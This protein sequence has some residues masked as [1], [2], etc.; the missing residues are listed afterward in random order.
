MASAPARRLSVTRS[1]TSQIALGNSSSAPLTFFG[2][3]TAGFNQLADGR[4]PYGAGGTLLGVGVR[5]LP[6]DSAAAN[7]RPANFSTQAQIK[8]FLHDLHL[9]RSDAKIS[10]LVGS[11]QVCDDLLGNMPDYHALAG[12]VAQYGTQ[13]AGDAVAA[14]IPGGFPAMPFTP[15]PVGSQDQITAVVSPAHGSTYSTTRTGGLLIQVTAFVSLNL[16]HGFS[17]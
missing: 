8:G 2:G 3:Q 16:T 10:F 12:M 11:T 1:F 5:L 14:V 15:H 6:G 13:A 7:H 9:L 17:A 4:L